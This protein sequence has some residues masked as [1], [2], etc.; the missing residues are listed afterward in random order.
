VNNTRS[1]SCRIAKLGCGRH[2]SICAAVTLICCHCATVV[3][4][5]GACFLRRKGA[6][7]SAISLDEAK[8][9][10]PI[11]TLNAVR[12]ATAVVP[13]T[14]GLRTAVH[15]RAEER[16]VNNT[17]SRSCR[18]A[19]LGCGRHT[20]ICAAVTLICCHCATVVLTGGACRLRSRG[21]RASAI[22]LDEAKLSIG[23]HNVVRAATA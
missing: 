4:T 10:C 19:K 21:A 12:A 6:R 15:G 1:R 22:S 14:A 9:S 20:S 23:A 13:S 17:R 3:L 2:T 5:G 18:I 8:P 11:L 7:T 16:I